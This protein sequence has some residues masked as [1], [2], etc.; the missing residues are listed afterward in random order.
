M[1]KHNFILVLHAHLPY[2]VNHG[3]WPHGTDWLHEAAAETYIPILRSFQALKADGINAKMTLNI[4]PILLEQLSMREFKAG[5]KDYLQIKIRNAIDDSIYFKKTGQSNLYD[6]ALFWDNYYRQT[7]EFFEEINENIVAEYARLDKEGSIEVITCAATHGYLP[8]LGNDNA[9]SGQIGTAVDCFKKHFKRKPRGI[10][11]PEN[12][13][14]PAY[15]WE[16]PL[17]GGEPKERQGVEEF[18]SKHGIKYFFTDTHMIRNSEAKGVYLERFKGLQALWEQFNKNS[19]G[20]NL[21]KELNEHNIYLIHEHEKDPV[22]VLIR[23]EKTGSQVWSAKDGYPGDPNYL[24]FHKKKF[25]G[26]HKYWRVTGGDVSLGDKLPYDPEEA[27]DRSRRHAEHFVSLLDNIA[28]KEK[29]ENSQIVALYDAELFGHW[30]FEGVHWIE[31]L[32]RNLAKST[33]VQAEFASQP[34]EVDQVR[35]KVSLPEGSWGQGGF[36]YIWMNDWTK[37]TWKLI[38]QAE[39][40]FVKAVQEHDRKDK[41]A[42]RI[43]KQLAR[44]LLLLESSDWQFLISTWSARD[45]SENRITFH[46][47]NFSKLFEHYSEY[48]ETGKFFKEGEALLEELERNDN[49]FKEVNIDHWA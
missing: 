37:W 8:L 34:V 42:R 47:E 12:A 19:T 21:D 24:E 29:K 40:T 38:Y 15:L 31:L 49:V 23:D 20:K 5:F 14:R 43:L 25:P 18:L 28:S 22:Y 2:V 16:S 39:D 3:T 13:Y 27:L 35:G 9:I 11:L 26:G 44:E 48:A 17:G 1:N 30:W 6:L 36:H 32:F 10:W 45:Y 4:T 7:L 41:L 46:W 33:K